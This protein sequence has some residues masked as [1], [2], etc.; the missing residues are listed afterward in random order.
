M[1]AVK[2]EWPRGAGA[3]STWSI[4]KRDVTERLESI[5]HR[6]GIR[7]AVLRSRVPPE[8]RESWYERQVRQRIEVVICHPKLVQTGLDLIQFPTLIFYETGYSI[9][10]LRQASRRSWRIGQKEPVKVKFLL[11]RHGPGQLLEVDGKEAAV[12]LAMEEVR[13]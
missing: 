11:R 8:Q 6:E 3:R 10:V 4:H 2:A 5:L 12:S 9:F 7:V 1:E 13:Q